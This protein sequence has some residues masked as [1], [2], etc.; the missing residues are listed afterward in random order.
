MKQKSLS[1]VVT[2]AMVVL[3]SEGKKMS[4]LVDLMEEMAAEVVILS[5]L[6]KKISIL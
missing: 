5:Y 6:L 2:E 1:R 3:A 4:N